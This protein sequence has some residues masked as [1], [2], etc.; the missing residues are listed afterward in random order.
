MVFIDEGELECLYEKVDSESAIDATVYKACWN[1]K[2]DGTDRNLSAGGNL[3]S[4][5]SVLGRASTYR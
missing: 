4:E 2:Y 1:N 5:Y 3:K